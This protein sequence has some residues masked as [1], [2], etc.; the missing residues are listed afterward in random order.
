MTPKDYKKDQKPLYQPKTTPAIVEVEEIQFVAVE[1]RGDPNDEN[2]EY[3]SAMEVLYGI[4]YTIKM[5]KKG[6]NVPKGYF[7]YVVPPYE[8]YL[9]DPRKTEISSLR[10]VL[11]VPVKRL[12]T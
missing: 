5:S 4:Q 9:S 7:D 12:R 1:G 6:N 10:T 2:G 11:R 3:Q 8:I